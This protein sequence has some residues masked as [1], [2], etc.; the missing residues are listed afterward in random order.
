MAADERGRAYFKRRKLMTTSG[1]I[2]IPMSLGLLSSMVLMAH[3]GGGIISGC[4]FWGSFAFG[5]ILW[6]IGK[7]GQ[8]C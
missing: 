6:E 4:M 1:K 2:L 5:V 3:G 8:K 7:A